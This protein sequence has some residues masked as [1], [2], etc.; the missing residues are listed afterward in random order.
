MESQASGLPV[1]VTD[2][3]GP[4]EVMRNHETGYVLSA[5]DDAAWVRAIVKLASDATLR[6]R[7]GKAAHEFMQGF[8]MRASFEH[9][10]SVHEATFVE[11]A[12][13]R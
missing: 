9:Y 12:R 11:H 13:S 10:W 6:E 4:K 1:L 5:R 3:G 7:M 8:S 2:V